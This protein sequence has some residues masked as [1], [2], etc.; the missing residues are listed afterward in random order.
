MAHLVRGAE[1]VLRPVQFRAGV[2]PPG[3]HRGRLCQPKGTD[4]GHNRYHD[5]DQ[6][7]SE[8][9]FNDADPGHGQIECDGDQVKHDGERVVTARRADRGC[10]QEEH[11]TKRASYQD[12]VDRLAAALSPVNVV[13]VEPQRELSKVSAAPAPNSAASTSAQGVRGL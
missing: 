1:A 12:R 11:G 13:Q 8:L 9:A 6:A 4:D 7:G 3:P 10:L 5:A 2:P